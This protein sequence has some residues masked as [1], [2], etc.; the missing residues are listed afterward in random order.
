MSKKRRQF[1][2]NDVTTRY[3]SGQSS[4]LM[5]PMRNT[6]IRNAVSTNDWSELIEQSKR[7]LER[8]F[9]NREHNIS[10]PAM[11]DRYMNCRKKKLKKVA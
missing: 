3:W 8:S 1:K 9:F 6:D 10:S 2:R 4:A 7:S 11:R 5:S